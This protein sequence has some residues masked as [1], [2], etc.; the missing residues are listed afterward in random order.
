MW[1]RAFEDA[2]RN[3]PGIR[4][5]RPEVVKPPLVGCFYTVA[6]FEMKRL[7]QVVVDSGAISAR[8]A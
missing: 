6:A 4:V 1:V 2:E 5:V 7:V 3:A 8:R